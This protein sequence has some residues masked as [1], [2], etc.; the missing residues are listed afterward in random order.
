MSAAETTNVAAST[1]N[2][3]A[4]GWSR[5]TPAIGTQSGVWVATIR[6]PENRANANGIVPYDDA[7]TRP[8]APGSPAGGTSDGHERV[9]GRQ[10]QQRHAFVNERDR[11]QPHDAPERD[12]GDEPGLDE[13]AGDHEAAP[14][15]A[16]GQHAADRR[17]EQRGDQA[18]HQDHPHG[19]RRAG[20]GAAPPR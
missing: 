1:K 8:F 3:A 20:E 16:V 7:I 12:G 4:S 17:G 19:E 2:G 5:S 18:N 6:S 13:V 14:V 10:E 15:Q 11:V 9:A